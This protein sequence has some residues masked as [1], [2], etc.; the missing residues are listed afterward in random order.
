MFEIQILQL[1]EQ[2]TTVAVKTIV[3]LA[4]V[5]SN[6]LSTRLSEYNVSLKI[7]ILAIISTM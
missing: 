5:L 3:Q 7:N 1:S 6:Y 2:P 4:V